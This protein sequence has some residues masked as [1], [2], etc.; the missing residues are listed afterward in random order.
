MIKKKLL[1]KEYF[2]PQISKIK[3]ER[4]LPL[5]KDE[6]WS[7]DLIDQLSLSKQNNDNFYFLLTVINVYTKC[8]WA[9][10]SIIFLVYL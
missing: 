10:P 1:A 5:Y 7:A 9:I 4:I 6:T 3:I 8:A 2:Y